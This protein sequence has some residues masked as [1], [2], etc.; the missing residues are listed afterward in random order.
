MGCSSNNTNTI[1]NNHLSDVGE[2]I[3]IQTNG[4]NSKNKEK[5][6]SENV[7]GISFR[8][9]YDIKDDNEIQI[10]NFKVSEKVD[11]INEEIKSKIKILNG[12]K[13]EDL[14]FKKKFNKMGIHTIDFIIEDSLTNMNFMFDNCTS[15]KSVEF[16]SIDTSRVKQMETMFHKC[17]E[18]ENLNLSNFDTSNVKRML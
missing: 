17:Y 8:C 7:N 4:D 12:N 11:I 10:I 2:D 15:L 5:L 18:L 16:I 6:K 1:D 9:T 13:K 14:V 3:N